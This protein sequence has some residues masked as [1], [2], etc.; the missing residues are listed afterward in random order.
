MRGTVNHV[1]LTVLDP[2]RSLSFYEA[3]L[4]FMGYRRSSSGA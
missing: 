3:V 1:D 4:G 2:E